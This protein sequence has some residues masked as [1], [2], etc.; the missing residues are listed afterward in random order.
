MKIGI[1]IRTFI[2]SQI[3]GVGV[4]TWEVLNYLFQ[5]DQQNQ[6]NL[7]Y[8][9]LSGKFLKPLQDFR[10]FSNVSLYY[11]HWPNKIFN[12]SL[13]YFHRPYLDK[14]MGGVDIIWFPNL[15][16]WQVSQQTKVVVT[17]HDLSFIRLP[18]AYNFKMRWWHKFVKARKKLQTADKIIAVSHNTK[19]DL[20]DIF[21]LSPEK[22]E[23][24]YSGIS[25]S[26][27]AKDP[28]TVKLKYH[29][30]DKFIL[31]LGTLE[32]RK[33]IEGV[34][35]AFKLINQPEFELVIAG[36][37]GWLYKN[38]YHLVEQLSLKGKVHFIGYI[39]PVDRF[40]FYQLAAL[41][42]WPSFYEG[43]GFPPLE[44]MKMGCPV[45]TSANSSLPEVVAEAALLVDPYNIKEIALAIKQLLANQELRH[46]LIVKGFENVKRFN[47]QQS[48]EKM[49][50]IFKSLT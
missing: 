19:K 26:L 41:L 12:F 29:L 30:P 15:N 11:Y 50:E 43:F 48:A 28:E 49:M 24:V 47:W 27:V 16:F 10:N 14:L 46:Q 32:P 36:R 3:T 22:I 4:Y 23:V 8:N 18:W 31:F 20:I 42:V 44:A 37:P 34:I 2:T 40:S 21:N 17:V 6:Y 39:D 38:I 1:D 35:Q 13:K 33:N 9:Q 5:L 45:I 25:S 7:F